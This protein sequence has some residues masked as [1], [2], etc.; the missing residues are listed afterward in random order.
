[1]HVTTE[2]QNFDIALTRRITV[3]I[4]HASHFVQ[5]EQVN[6]FKTTISHSGGFPEASNSHQPSSKEYQIHPLL[7]P[8]SAQSVIRRLIFEIPI[9]MSTKTWFQRTTKR[10]SR[11][12]QP[13][14]FLLPSIYQYL[15]PAHIRHW[16]H[17]FYL[18]SQ[19]FVSPR[20]E[21]SAQ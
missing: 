3:G 19:Q 13:I 18:P 15:P 6:N 12:R 5:Y 16:E 9:V 21:L 20:L 14:R 11:Q 8:Q 7:L 10:R 17:L 1:M 4:R 2:R